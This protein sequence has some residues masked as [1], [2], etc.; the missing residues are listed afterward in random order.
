MAEE[1]MLFADRSPRQIEQDCAHDAQ[2]DHQHS[3]EHSIHE[4][5][6]GP[7]SGPKTSTRGLLKSGDAL[8]HI[9]IIDVHRVDLG[10]TL[11][12]RVRLARR[13]LCYTQIIPQS[14]DTFRFEVRSVQRTVV[15]DRCDARLSLFHQG[16]SQERASLHGVP[17]RPP[18]IRRLAP[19]LTL[20]NPSF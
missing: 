12:R 8:T 18:A 13:L 3:A 17:E 16:K 14:E 1:V 7:A 10:K 19:L 15:P 2:D 5:R 6:V 9:A 11:Q 20:A 4:W